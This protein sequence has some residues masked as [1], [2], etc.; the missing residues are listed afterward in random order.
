MSQIERLAPFVSG[1]LV[2]PDE[3]DESDVLLG[4]RA[5]LAFLGVPC[6]PH[7]RLDEPFFFHVVDVIAGDAVVDELAEALRKGSAE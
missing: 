7:F 4:E 2:L 3:S 1:T 6:P 5:H